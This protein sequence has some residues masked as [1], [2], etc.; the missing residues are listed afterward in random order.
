[1]KNSPILNTILV[2]DDETSILKVLKR[3]LSRNGYAVDIAA[4]GEE[5][6]RKIENNEYSLIITDIK[7][8]GISGEQVFSYLRNEIKKTTPIV[9]MSGTPWLLE[10]IGFDAVLSKPYYMKELLDLIG[11]LIE[12]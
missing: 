1:M 7:M 10:H 2:I 12:H 6:I 3:F 9:G 5:G 11:Q 8:T 4:D